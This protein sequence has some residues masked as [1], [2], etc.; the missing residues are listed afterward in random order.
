MIAS[1]YDMTQTS[2]Y[3]LPSELQANL[4]PRPEGGFLLKAF[5]QESNP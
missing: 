2:W 1:H 4:I 5:F 3:E